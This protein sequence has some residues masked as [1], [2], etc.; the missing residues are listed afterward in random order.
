MM[1]RRWRTT[2]L[3]VPVSVKLLWNTAAINAGTVS[4][5]K[6]FAALRDRIARVRC[7]I[8]LSESRM[9]PAC[10]CAYFRPMVASS[11]LQAAAMYDV[12]GFDN[13]A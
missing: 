2:M 3:N 10:D 6:A 12:A 1:E 11:S 7:N 9:S 4:S 5:A 8:L 13:G